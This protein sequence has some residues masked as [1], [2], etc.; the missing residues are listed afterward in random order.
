[1]EKKDLSL[2]FKLT[3]Y[4]H[5][6]IWLVNFTFDH[7]NSRLHRDSLRADDTGHP[8]ARNR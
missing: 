2:S 1:M 6:V 7:G 5:Y 3:A 8:G 4:N